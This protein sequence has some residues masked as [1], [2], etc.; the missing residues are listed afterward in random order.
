MEYSYLDYLFDDLIEEG[1]N[2]DIISM[3][4]KSDYPDLY[5][6]VPKL[7]NLYRV[8]RLQKRKLKV[9]KEFR[10]FMKIT[11]SKSLEDITNYYNNYTCKENKNMCVI[12]QD[13]LNN[14]KFIALPCNHEYHLNCLN[15][16]ITYDRKNKRKDRYL[17]PICKY[18][19]M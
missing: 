10:E 18:Q 7:S 9:S 6:Y 2:N 14:T 1:E 12:C 17:C 5:K 19:F 3:F 15:D 11:K 13:T 16:L 8:Q 4:D